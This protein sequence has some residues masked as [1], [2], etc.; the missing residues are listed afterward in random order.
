ME[1]FLNQSWEVVRQWYWL[2][3]AFVYITII[4]TILIENRQPAKTIAWILVILLLPGAGIVFYYLFGQKF[5]KVKIFR[6]KNKEQ[7]LKLVQRWNELDIMLD[8]NLEAIYKDI[9]SLAKVFAFI[10][11]QKVAPPLLGNKVELLI[12]GESKF[13]EMLAS[14][15]GARHHIHL[16][17]YIFVPDEIGSR[18]MDLL[19]RKASEGV[20]VRMIADAFGSPRMRRYKKRLEKAGVQFVSFLPV[21]I[22]SLANSNYRNHRKIVI[23]DGQIAFVGGINVSDYYINSPRS[24]RYWR[25][26]SV[27]IVGQSVDILQVYFWL[28]WRFGK[29][30]DYELSVDY[31]F[32]K[33]KERYKSLPAPTTMPAHSAVSFVYS[34][35]GSPAPYNMEALLIAIAEATASIRLCTPYFIPSDELSTAL[36]LAAAS[37]VRVELM[38]PSKADSY[39]VHHASLSF[40]KPLLRRGVKVYLYEKGFMHAKTVCVDG[41]LAFIGTVNLDIRSFYINFEAT[42]LIVDTVLCAELD[43]Q[44]DRDKEVS[45]L[46]D[47]E[48]WMLRPKWKRGLDSL[49]RLL[50]PLL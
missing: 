26:T 3:L 25:D 47:L 17:Y 15:E 39:I 41:K 43:A 13:P 5:K 21:T 7:N 34:D 6:G 18:I 8:A 32:H 12:N 36:Q 20:K 46:I 38:M 42:A 1:V 50:A 19:I 11:S 45:T 29:G 14:I 27:K 24:K 23:I 28:D 35:P 49:C 40:I 37:G 16:E 10:D 30:E 9:G 44:F 4:L 31:L 48:R 2:P 33:K 22:A